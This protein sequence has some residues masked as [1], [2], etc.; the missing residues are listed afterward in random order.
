MIVNIDK[1]V[2]SMTKKQFDGVLK[3]ASKQVPFGIYAVKKDGIC[4]LHKDHFDTKFKLQQAVKEY[5]GN[6]FKVYY[7]S[8]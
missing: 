2:Y 4:E 5:A 1:S 8:K 7:N 6:G 3:V